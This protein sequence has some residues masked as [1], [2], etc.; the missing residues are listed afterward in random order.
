[1]LDQRVESKLIVQLARE[2]QPSI[3]SDRRPPELD[4]KLRVEREANRARFR[5]THW[6]MPSAPARHPRNPPVEKPTKTEQHFGS[7]PPMWCAQF[8]RA[9]SRRSDVPDKDRPWTLDVESVLVARIA[10]SSDGLSRCARAAAVG[11]RNVT[12]ESAV[13]VAEIRKNAK[14]H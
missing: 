11:K 12:K 13:S 10:E 8:G 9:A 6:M 7:T 4:S 1:M 2:Q 5:V 14:S 3:G